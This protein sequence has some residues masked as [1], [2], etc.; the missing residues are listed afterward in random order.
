MSHLKSKV[1]KPAPLRVIFIL[2][3]LM[4]ILPFIFYWVF[5]TENITVGG[6]DPLWMVYTGVAY[7]LSFILLVYCL[8]SRKLFG[9]RVIFVINIFIAI[10]ASA[11]IGVLVALTSLILSFFNKKILTYFSE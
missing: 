1:H 2:N 4:A 7:I 3:A 11:F 8:K 6:L 5:K 10:P 9:A